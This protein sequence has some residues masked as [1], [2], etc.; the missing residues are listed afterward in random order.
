MVRPFLLSGVHTRNGAATGQACGCGKRMAGR[1]AAES[2]VF[3]IGVGTNEMADTVPVKPEAQN[4]PPI[5]K[6]VSQA[7]PAPS[8]AQKPFAKVKAAA[9][10]A[11]QAQ[12][13]PPQGAKVVAAPTAEKPPPKV[14]AAIAAA[15]QTQGVPSQA[16][17][18][19]AAPAACSWE[20]LS[21]HQAGR[22]RVRRSWQ[23]PRL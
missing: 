3:V 20:R 14:K 1:G 6:A 5:G 7:A 11:A 12:G 8:K 22:L 13:G 4:L 15:A 9:A 16:A 21:R 18:L 2:T 10:T 19:K 23:H 17:E